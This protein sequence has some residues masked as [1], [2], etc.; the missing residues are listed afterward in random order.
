MDLVEARN[1]QKTREISVSFSGSLFEICQMQEHMKK[2][3]INL[4]ILAI[5]HLKGQLEVLSQ[6]RQMAIPKLRCYLLVQLKY[7][8]SLSNMTSNMHT[9]IK[10]AKL[11]TSIPRGTTPLFSWSRTYSSWLFSA[12]MRNIPSAFKHEK[13][14]I[15]Q[16]MQRDNQ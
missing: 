1:K 8:K 14:G 16:I 5:N 13:N 11:W 3:C 2:I 6:S 7:L 9:F 4:K 15:T 12:F 10:P